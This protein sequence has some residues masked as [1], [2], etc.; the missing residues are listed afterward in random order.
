MFQ[1]GTAVLPAVCIIR[2]IYV[3]SSSAHY[4][5]KLDR[6]GVSMHIKKISMLYFEVCRYLVRVRYDMGLDVFACYII[7]TYRVAI[8]HFVQSFT[9]YYAS[10]QYRY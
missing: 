8:N 9:N 6:Q 4:D 3:H 10:L 5:Q 7:R 1:G 2:G